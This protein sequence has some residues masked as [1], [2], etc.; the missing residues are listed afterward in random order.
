MSG[1]QN[2]ELHALETKLA[3]GTGSGL[4]PSLALHRIQVPRVDVDRPLS[5]AWRLRRNRDR[6]PVATIFLA[7]HLV[8]IGGEVVPLDDP[9]G[10][11]FTPVFTPF[12]VDPFH[13]VD[14]QTRYEPLDAFRRPDADGW[15][16]VDGVLWTEFELE[17]S[18]GPYRVTVKKSG[19]Y[20]L[21]CETCNWRGHGKRS[22]TVMSFR[23]N[24]DVLKHTCPAANPRTPNS[25]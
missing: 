23:L 5:W 13:Q 6:R 17:H 20:A 14:G 4:I 2:E 15:D 16:V 3:G 7:R 24:G 1:Q 11:D 12:V 10:E 21:S 8:V 19:D 22:A 18:S 9:D 25:K